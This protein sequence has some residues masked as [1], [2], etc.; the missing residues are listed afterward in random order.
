MLPVQLDMFDAM[1]YTHASR[2][3][4]CTWFGDLRRVT[5]PTPV[6]ILYLAWH[7][8]I[9]CIRISVFALAE[10]VLGL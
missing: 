1:W 9:V 8:C 7:I 2:L 4:L 10:A 6:D 5:Q 3:V